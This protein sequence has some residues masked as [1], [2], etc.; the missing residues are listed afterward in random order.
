MFLSKKY[1]FHTNHTCKSHKF[2]HTEYRD[3]IWITTQ[4]V[5]RAEMHSSFSKMLQSSYRAITTIHP[6]RGF[7]M[8]TRVV[9]STT[10]TLA[11]DSAKAEAGTS[12]QVKHDHG[13]KIPL[14]HRGRT[15]S[16]HAA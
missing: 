6:H 11:K 10:R 12:T 15:A 7:L 8:P 3:R 13:T 14:A 5:T 4:L 9:S 16:I 1:V 2:L